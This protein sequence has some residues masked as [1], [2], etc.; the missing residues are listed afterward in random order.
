MKS[1]NSEQIVILGDKT[2]GG[3][4]MPFSAELPNGWRVRFSASPHYD[5]NMNSIEEGIMPDIKIDMAMEDMLKY[6]DTLIEEA[7]KVINQ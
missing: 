1:I 2:G 7:Y 6:K 4:G 5:K 3:S